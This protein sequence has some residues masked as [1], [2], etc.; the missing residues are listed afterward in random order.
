M[1]IFCV[2]MAW[3]SQ[4]TG[5]QR[6]N[7]VLCTLKFQPHMTHD[8]TKGDS[9]QEDQK[10]PSPRL[11]WPGASLRDEGNHGRF[12][13]FDERILLKTWFSPESALGALH[14]AGFPS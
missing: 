8:S 5:L 6:P 4:I 14:N 1:G 10:T 7:L 9:G 2:E 13:I 12:V 11:R 3:P